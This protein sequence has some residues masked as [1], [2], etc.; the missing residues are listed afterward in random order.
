MVIGLLQSCVMISD[1]SFW[2]VCSLLPVVS[3]IVENELFLL[4][5]W[6]H[7]FSFHFGKVGERFQSMINFHL[8]RG[9]FPEDCFLFLSNV[10]IWIPARKVQNFSGLFSHDRSIEI[11]DSI[12]GGIGL[13]I[14]RISWPR[15]ETWNLSFLYF[16]LLVWTLFQF[17]V[18]LCYPIGV[19]SW[20]LCKAQRSFAMPVMK[21]IN[22]CIELWLIPLCCLRWQIKARFFLV[23]DR[24]VLGQP[25]CE[26]V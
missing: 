16:D 2:S 17:S 25:Y 20:H 24:N 15:R 12:Y 26:F 18:L 5:N 7:N 23:K 19:S 8:L 13:L 11:R 10:V 9:F 4:L 22:C 1:V 6:F 14:K 21:L 3:R